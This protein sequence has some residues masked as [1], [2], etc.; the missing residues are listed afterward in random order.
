[1]DSGVFEVVLVV[2]VDLLRCFSFIMFAVHLFSLR[3]ILK[4]AFS[5]LVLILVI[6]IENE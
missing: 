1:M 5:S 2:R 4:Y 6:N 3:R